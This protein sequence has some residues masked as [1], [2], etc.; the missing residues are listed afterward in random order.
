M[1]RLVQAGQART[2]CSSAPMW[3]R[4]QSTVLASSI[5]RSRVS[6]ARGSRQVNTEKYGASRRRSTRWTCR[7]CAMT[8]HHATPPIP[9]LGTATTT[10]HG[11]ILDPSMALNV[12]LSMALNMVS[13]RLVAAALLVATPTIVNGQ[14]DLGSLSSF[15]LLAAIGLTSLGTSIV[16]GNIGTFPGFYMTGFPPGIVNNGAI[17]GPDAITQKA[18]N[19]LSAAMSQ[20]IALTATAVSLSLELG[21]L[22]FSPGVIDMPEDGSASLSSTVYLFTNDMSA[23]WIFRIPGSFSIAPTGAVELINGGVSCNVIWLVGNEVFAEGPSTLKG[24]F[25]VGRDI[26]LGNGTT[27]MGGLYSSDGQVALDNGTVD[28]C[29][30][31]PRSETTA[32]AMMSTVMTDTTAAE[33]ASTMATDITATDTTATTATTLATSLTHSGSATA[34]T[35]TPT[36]TA[37]GTG[38]SRTAATGITSTANVAGRSRSTTATTAT[39]TTHPGAAEATLRL[40]SRQ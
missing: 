40:P 29:V 19:D 4:S 31:P 14:V 15:G 28:R 17:Y 37:G 8:R 1:N 21:G 23:M 26:I 3:G 5:G 6:M 38:R 36:S 39:P 13:I 9:P 34:S 30:F 16:D 27:S 10:F 25:L 33:T 32:T 24:N 18:H 20:A 12:A 35:T 2:A 7:E 11:R 22:V